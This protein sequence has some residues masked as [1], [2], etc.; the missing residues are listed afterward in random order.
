MGKA[1]KTAA[2]IVVIGGANIDIQGQASSVFRLG[3]SNPGR[4]GT[5]FGGVGRNVAEACVRLGLELSLITV[6]GGDPDGERMEAD[7]RAKGIDTGWSLHREGPS[8]RYLCALDA[9]GSLVGAVADMEAL[10]VLL[11]RHLDALVKDLDKAACIV[12]DTNIPRDSLVWLCRR[13][14]RRSGVIQSAGRPLLFLDTVSEAK[15]VKASGL[16]GEFDCIKPNMREAMI[17]ASGGPAPENSDENPA[18]IR[19]L[20]ERR[21]SLPVELY[22][23][24]GSKGMYYSA[25]GEAGRIPLPPEE[26]RPSVRNRSGAGDCALAGLVWASIEGCKPREKVYYALSAALL[27]SASAQPVPEDLDEKKLR[28][29]A[30]LIAEKE[31]VR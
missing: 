17:M 11:P 5:A 3:D 6:F 21:D 30:A 20:I 7:C 22:I 12:A 28:S 1:R 9:D 8:A 2:Q 31:L 10:D 27:A 23:S 14:G 24:L 25:N 4:I 16:F 15:A 13:Y 18:L 26:L 19:A 29:L